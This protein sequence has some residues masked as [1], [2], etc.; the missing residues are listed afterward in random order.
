MIMRGDGGV[1]DISEMKK[2]PVLTMLSGPAASVMGSLMYLRASNGVYFEVGGTSTNIGVIK[3]GRPAIDYSIVGGHSTY[4]SSLDV[5]VLG[6]MVRANKSG[7]VDVGP[8]SAHIAGLEYSVF[9]EGEKIKSPQVEFFSPKAGDPSDYVAIRLENGERVTLTNSCAANVLGLV[10]PEHF[11]YGYVESARKAMKALADYCQTTVEDIAT[12]IM[13]K[14]FEKIE[15]VI[16]ALAEKYKLEHDQISLV[17]VGG[18]AASLICYCAD[19]MNLKYSIP[20]NAEVISSIGVALSMVRDVVE[21]II[22]T[23]SKED[24]RSIKQEAMNKAIESGATPESVEI[25]IEIDPQT[26]K[27]TAIAMGST[28]V[29]AT[30][31]LKECSEEEARDLAAADLRVDKDQVELRAKTDYFYV[32]GQKQAVPDAPT[33][34]RILDKKGFIKAQRGYAVSVKVQAKDYINAV[35][36]MWETMATYKTD[37]IIRPEYYLCMGAKMMDFSVNDYEQLQMLMDLEVMNLDPDT[38]IIVTAANQKE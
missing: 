16:L 27:V 25:H 18:G 24:I 33:A 29:K 6:S 20:E 11:S 9:T 37:L 17:G 8:R 22:P 31:L 30:D 32:Y 10:Q 14:S 28:E 23:P 13:Q 26:S 38:E 5:R 15:P 7:I 4:I 1:M 35:E 21:R 2:R 12:Q 3:N 19:K 34:V 36:D